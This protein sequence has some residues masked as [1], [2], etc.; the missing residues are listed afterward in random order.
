MNDNYEYLIQKRQEVLEAI[1]PICEAFKIKD[2]DYEIL[3]G[4]REV[5]R[6]GSTRIWCTWNSI[7]AVID[8]LIGY[9]FVTIWCKNRSLG[10]FETQTINRIKDCWSKAVVE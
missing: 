10:A 7:S 9:I 6:I 4:G 1:S 5:L 2:Y 3:P 8:E